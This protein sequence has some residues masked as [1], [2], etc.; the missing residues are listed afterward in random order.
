MQ[1]F[2][3]KYLAEF[4]LEVMMNGVKGDSKCLNIWNIKVNLLTK[5]EIVDILNKWIEEGKKGMYFTPVDAN[6]VMLAQH[7]EKLRNAILA[8][9][10]TNVDSFLP[11]KYLHEYGYPINGRVA[12][13]DVMDLVL[14]VASKK[15]QRVFFLGAKDTTLD[16]LRDVVT[17]R[18]PGV[19]IAGM[20]N[21]YFKDEE[22]SSVADFISSTKPDIVFVG[23]PSPKKENFVLGCKDTID[24]GALYCVGGAFD[25][26]AGILPRPPKW[27]Q[28]GPM[29]GVF[30]ILR[31]PKV[32]WYRAVMCFKF[33]HF[34][35][36]WGRE[37]A[38]K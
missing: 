23:M 22:N 4:R 3:K 10:I 37:H 8:S 30:R 28:K 24:A 2:T 12:T 14:E 13:P 27:V 36:K 6:T 16:L 20:R 34:A 11:S 21:G 38:N 35:K 7:D 32:Y 26:L 33:M 5:E 25:A 9:D 29:E 17:K 18:F 1:I 31:N 15:K 19:V